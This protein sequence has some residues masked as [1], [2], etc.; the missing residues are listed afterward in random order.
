MNL[1]NCISQ[2]REHWKEFQPT[3]FKELQKAGKLEP[4]LKEAAEKTHQEMTELEAQG[5][6]EWEAWEMVRES[7]LFPPEEQSLKDQ[8]DN[9]PVASEAARLFNEIARLKSEILRGEIGEE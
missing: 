3:R 6:Q 7:Y 4:A 8:E 1:Q 5:F 9:E 2:A